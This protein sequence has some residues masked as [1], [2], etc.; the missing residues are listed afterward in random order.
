MHFVVQIESIIL[1][2]KVSRL[3]CKLNFGQLGF[4][5]WN[6]I[7]THITQINTHNVLYSENYH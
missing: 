4:K 3:V 7:Y 6:H 1:A 2:D 5:I